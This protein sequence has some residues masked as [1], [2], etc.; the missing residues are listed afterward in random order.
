MD[1]KNA[2]VLITGGSEG[3]GRGLAAR[4]LSAGSS[5]LVTGRSKAKLEHAARD[6][7]GL[8][9]QVSDMADPQGR[10]SLV[11]QVRA[12]LPNINVLINNAG[13]QRRVA[14]ADDMA[15]WEE[16]QQEVDTLFCGPAHLSHLLIPLLLEQK[17]PSLLVNVTSGGAFV[18][19]TFAP[20]YSACKAAL[21]SYTMTL[22]HALA[23]TAC[24]VV[25]IIPPAVQTSIAA[26]AAAHGVPLEQFCDAVFQSLN[27]TDALEISY[28]PAERVLNAS[29]ADL[30]SAFD[31][32]AARF[33]VSRYS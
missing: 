29:R 14:L 12:Q 32:S 7:P 2:A 24:R 4:F 18:P 28:G 10:E 22:R 6:L 30:N 33:K 25:E 17:Q 1:L 13:G 20:L 31:A 9:T 3:I 23:N 19:Q 16:R 27:Q 8:K 21:H 15:P 5:V 26:G 11:Q